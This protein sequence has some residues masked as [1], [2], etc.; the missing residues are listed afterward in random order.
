MIRERQFFTPLL[1]AACCAAFS[2]VPFFLPIFLVW[3]WRARIFSRSFEVFVFV[4]VSVSVSP[5][6][7]GVL[8]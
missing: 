4:S 3:I 1:P 7:G 6:C 8:P 2:L 5:F